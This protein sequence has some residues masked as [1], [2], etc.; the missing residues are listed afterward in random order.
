MASERRSETRAAHQAGTTPGD[1]APWADLEMTV[2]TDR[3]HASVVALVECA[4]VELTHEAV[5]AVLISRQV[6]RSTRTQY[7]ARDDVGEQ[8]QKRRFDDRLGWQETTI[9]R[10]TVRDEL[11]TQLTRSP[12]TPVEQSGERAATE[13]DTFVVKPVRELQTP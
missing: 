13:P 5:G 3:D 7:V 8:F 10:R 9:P 1:E 6:G 11:I 4:L 12:S 2:P